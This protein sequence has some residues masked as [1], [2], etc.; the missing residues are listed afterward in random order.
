MRRQLALAALL[1]TAVA[2]P[3]TAQD[4]RGPYRGEPRYS[5]DNR[6]YGYGRQLSRGN[7]VTAAMRDLEAIFRRARVDRHEAN[8]FRRA[9][10]ELAEFERR[11]VHGRFDRGTLDDAIGN[12]ADLAQADQ[13]HPR[14]RQIIRMRMDDLRRFRYSNDR[15]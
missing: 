8:H 1:A 11:A 6:D 9:L 5:R 3:S 12:M 4:R 14:D 10:N 2:V 15:Y 13:L 7:P